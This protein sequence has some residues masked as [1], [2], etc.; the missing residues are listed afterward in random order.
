MLDT[1]SSTS[2]IDLGTLKKI[3]LDEN[4][5]KQAAKSLINASGD[6]MK[7]LG[8]VEIAVT[9]PGSQPRNQTF[10]VLDSI[11]YSNILLGRDF[12]QTYGSVHFDFARNKIEMGAFSTPGL[13]TTKK[14]VKLSEASTIPARSEKVLLVKGSAQNA[15]L[16]SDFEPKIRPNIR[17]LYATRSRVIPN[18]DGVFAVTVLNVSTS[19]ICLKSRTLMGDLQPTNEILAVT[20]ELNNENVF[21]NNTRFGSQLSTTEIDQIK[22]LINDYQDIF[23]AN[24]KK[25]KRTDLIE[26]QIITNDA[27]P[28]YHKP[29]RILTA[30]E[31][32]VDQQVSEMLTNDIIRPSYSPWN[33]P[34]ILVKKKDNTNRFVCDFR[35]VNDVTKKDTYPLPHI[36]DVIDK[37][38]GSK[39]WSTLDAALAYW[40][41]P[42]SEIDKE[43]TAFS[44]PR[45]KFEFNV[46][47]FGLSNSGATYQR[48]MDMCLSG[49]PTDKVLSYMDDIVVFNCN[50]KDHIR[51]LKAVFD[52]LRSAKVSLKA[53]KCVFADTK[54]DFLGFELSVDG[55]KPQHRLTEAIVKFPQPETKKELRRFLGMAG[56]YRAFIKDFATISQPLNKLTSDNTKFIWDMACEHAFQKL[57]QQLISEPILAFPKPNDTFVVEVDASDYAAGGVLS[58]EGP[59]HVLHPVAYFSTAFTNSQRN[60]AAITKEAFALVLAVRHWY[61]YLTGN[62]FTL[63]S[64]HNP[65]VHLRQQKDPRGK[66]GRWITE[67][68]EYN[69][70]VEYIRGKDNV[71]ADMLSRNRLA[72]P[73]QPDS[74]FEDK[75]FSTIVDNAAFVEQLKQ[76]Q[77]TDPILHRAKSLIQNSDNIVEGRFKRIQNQLRIENE[78]LTKSGR[79][80]IPASLRKFVVTEM[81]KSAHFGTDKTYA[82]L[83]DRFFWPNMYSYVRNFVTHCEVCQQTKCNSS[84]PKAPLQPMVS[85]DAPMRFIS[86][87][88]AFMPKD[89]HGF[90]Y[91]LL[92]G[93]IFS[94]YIQAVPLKDQT[95]PVIADALLSHWIYHHGTPYFLLSDQGSNVDGDVIRD[96]CN[97]LGIEKRRSSAYHSQGNGFAERNIRSVK[98]ML[99]S[100]L[101]QRKAPQSKW[102]TFLPELVFALNTSLS[103]ATKC[104]PYN[105]VFGR[106]ARLPI[107]ILFNHDN[108]QFNDDTAPTDYAEER[109]F[110]LKDIFE[111]VLKNLQLNS[112]KMQAQYNKNIR[113]HDYRE[114]DRVWLSVKYY[115]TG[116][117]R[118]LS[119]RRRGPWTV[120]QKLPNGLNFKIF[121]NHTRETK[122]VH[123]DRLTPFKETADADNS[124]CNLDN[125]RHNS[126]I[127]DNK[128]AVSDVVESSEYESSDEE[129][130]ESTSS[131]NFQSDMDTNDDD[132]EPEILHREYPRRERRMRQFPGNIP[133]DAVRL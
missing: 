133:W 46:M 122:I 120:M 21:T 89:N 50:F 5:N 78:I 102:R 30:W 55:I 16:E 25:P 123:H 114:G 76:A 68:E 88:I 86:I 51:D 56:F 85:P 81:H 62:Q 131:D 32:D 4:L 129:S 11:T 65:L 67:L 127:S 57:K 116:E 107:D 82:L 3:G 106:S 64:D 83:Q 29:R 119:P 80:I 96:I 113:F 22:T 53:S 8:S 23:A 12:M 66:F 94:K 97:L 9:L 75:I 33:A 128:S 100:I 130:F 90:Q 34:V 84:P 99:R 115:K 91:F 109:S 35:G 49:L 105:V 58:Q 43:K 14:Q 15:L 79:P 101:L 59:D 18:I 71:Q 27:L 1:G 110:I 132:S 104:I 19:E 63:R 117:N 52:C 54:V 47:P 108:T 77:D 124:K 61:V 31:K 74:S 39:Y 10:Q 69:Y 44:V 111:V 72:N 73:D 7:I 28:V 125:H 17:G 48:M 37:M 45:G 126:N 60:W 95:A 70:K 98:E 118:K 2:V 41:I 20:K 92:I 13:S 26:H 24:P 112:E 87:D 6:K 36:K 42:L 121:N 103:K 38:A 93:D 40:S